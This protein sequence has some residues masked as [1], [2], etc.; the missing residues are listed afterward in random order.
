METAEMEISAHTP[1][2]HV[3][4]ALNIKPNP[5]SHQTPHTQTIAYIR[6]QQKQKPIQEPLWN[7]Q[8]PKPSK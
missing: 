5:V 6:L 1:M 4:I 8:Q 3:T 2:T 7:R